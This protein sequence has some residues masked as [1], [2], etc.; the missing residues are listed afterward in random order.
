MSHD[1][2]PAPLCRVCGHP[3]HEGGAEHAAGMCR[4][5]LAKIGIVLLI[6]MIITSYV[7]WFGLL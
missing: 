6:I 5:C 4:G 7:V 1:N 3:E 2:K